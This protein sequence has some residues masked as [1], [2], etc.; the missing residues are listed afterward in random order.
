[1][2]VH[3]LHQGQLAHPEGQP[4]TQHPCAE[5]RPPTLMSEPPLPQPGR[6]SA[7]PATSSC[8][9]ALL[10]PLRGHL[11]LPMPLSAAGNSRYRTPPAPVPSR[12]AL[13]P[14]PASPRLLG[15]LPLHWGCPVSRCD[16][17][18]LACASFL[19]AVRGQHPP[20]PPRTVLSLELWPCSWPGLW[21]E[22][23]LCPAGS[24][25]LRNGATALSSGAGEGLSVLGPGGLVVK[26]SNPPPPHTHTRPGRASPHTPGTASPSSQAPARPPQ[27]GPSGRRVYLVAGERQGGPHRNA[28]DGAGQRGGE[29][30]L[31]GA[32]GT[33]PHRAPRQQPLG[34]RGHGCRGGGL[35][36]RGWH[37]GGST[38]CR[39][40]RS[41]SH[42]P[43]LGGLGAS[44]QERVRSKGVRSLAAARG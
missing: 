36:P 7:Q 6:P 5:G 16:R 24:G 43:R 11:V 8:L 38:S 41:T 37:Q 29:E 13:W 35:R 21:G 18:G 10:A 17:S 31:G 9:P 40:P 19:R 12:P 28:R 4:P 14:P 30:E 23:G 22:K 1:M 32:L 33:V 15:L 42:P 2:P 39:E 26:P 44:E 25:S 3:F 20:T 34:L 27:Q